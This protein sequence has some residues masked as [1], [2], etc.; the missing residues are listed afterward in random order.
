MFKNPHHVKDVSGKY[1]NREVDKES[2]RI[3]WGHKLP[4]RPSIHKGAHG[5]PQIFATTCCLVRASDVFELH[6][7]SQTRCGNLVS[8]PQ[9]LQNDR[10]ERAKLPVEEWGSCARVGTLLLL[11]SPVPRSCIETRVHPTEVHWR[12]KM[13]GTCQVCSTEPAKYRC[14]SCGLMR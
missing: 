4:S 6:S 9:S 11:I 13:P 8:L 3:H 7:S 1:G 10:V 2:E 5:P 12:D 14:P